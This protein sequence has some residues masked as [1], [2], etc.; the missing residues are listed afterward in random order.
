M[1]IFGVSVF[2][3]FDWEISFAVVGVLFSLTTSYSGWLRM[4][5]DFGPFTGTFKFVWMTIKS[6]LYMA[7]VLT[8]AHGWIWA[9][10]A[11]AAILI[12]GRPPGLEHHPLF[13][14]RLMNP[15]REGGRSVLCMMTMSGAIWCLPLSHG[16]VCPGH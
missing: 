7:N 15:L 8:Y 6:A 13:T 2:S 5:E 10:A 12:P 1:V 9:S 3:A 14:L 16:P 4:M 11:R